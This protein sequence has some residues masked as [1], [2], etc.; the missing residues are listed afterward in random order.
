MRWPVLGLSSVCPSKS[1]SPASSPLRVVPLVNH[2]IPRHLISAVFKRTM[3]QRLDDQ[4]ERQTHA[5]KQNSAEI[6]RDRHDQRQPA[7]QRL[8][9]IKSA[10]L[11]RAPNRNRQNHSRVSAAEQCLLGRRGTRQYPVDALLTVAADGYE[12]LKTAAEGERK[13][14]VGCGLTVLSWQDCSRQQRGSGTNKYGIELV[15]LWDGISQPGIRGFTAV[16]VND[17]RLEATDRPAR[18]S[19]PQA[20]SSWGTTGEG[21][22]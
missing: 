10:A 8:A 22:S 17:K 20:S 1:I 19:S 18:R 12:K 4:R 7:R 11:I 13:R 14:A 2:A 16:Q 15:R 5:D 21:G 6:R 9:T 3:R